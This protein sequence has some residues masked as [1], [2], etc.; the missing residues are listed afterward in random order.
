MLHRSEHH[1]RGGS[2]SVRLAARC[3]GRHTAGVRLSERAA[4]VHRRQPRD[5]SAGQR[6]VQPYNQPPQ[7]EPTGAMPISPLNQI[8]FFL[9][10]ICKK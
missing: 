5:Q 10:N 2:R 6:G 3:R 8:E 4:A 7:R 9:N 1:G